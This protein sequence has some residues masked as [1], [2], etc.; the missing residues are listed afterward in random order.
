MGLLTPDLGYFFW[1][2][3]AFVV[4]FLVLKKFAWKPIIKSL[5]ER[6]QTIAGAIASAEKV[7]AEMA[8][9]QSENES[10]LAKAREERSQLLKEARETKDKIVNEAK[11]QAKTEASKIIAD[12]QQ[13]INAQK[14]AALTEVKNEV[15][16]MVIEVSEKVLR[17]QL[18]GEAK[19]EAYIN[20]LVDS[21]KLN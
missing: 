18:S 3:V 7:K 19:Q 16:K 5:N 20:G 14:M 13:A 8:Q 21:V 11:E 1:I 12:A 17:Q 2:F 9:L 6:E 4:V 15:G 10:L